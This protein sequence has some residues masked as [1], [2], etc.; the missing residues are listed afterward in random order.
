[1][2]Y[3]PVPLSITIFVYIDAR[4]SIFSVFFFNVP[5][6]SSILAN[7]ICTSTD[8]RAVIHSPMSLLAR[9]K[10]FSSRSTVDTSRT[11]K[12]TIPLQDA[13]RLPSEGF[14][15][16]SNLA[17]YTREYVRKSGPHSCLKCQRFS[18]RAPRCTDSVYTCSFCPDMY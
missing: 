18:H 3:C 17:A 7:I 16:I 4:L 8:E 10:G 2:L 1:V 5:L 6:D 15:N 14:M 11:Q 12:P 13:Q 9:L